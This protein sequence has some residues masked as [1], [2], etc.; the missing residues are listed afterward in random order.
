MGTHAEER[1][2][3]RRR[4]WSRCA[5]R[6]GS[7][8]DPWAPEPAADPPAPAEGAT[9]AAPSAGGARPAGHDATNPMLDLVIEVPWPAPDGPAAE[10]VVVQHVL[11]R[12]WSSPG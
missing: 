7:A 4:T 12:R 6:P 5:S 2:R 3:A 8:D 9:E 1:P 11:W 10:G